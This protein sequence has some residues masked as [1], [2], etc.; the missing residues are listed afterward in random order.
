MT[1]ER[2][3]EDLLREMVHRTGENLTKEQTQQFVRYAELLRRWNEKMNLT[4]IVD[5]EGIAVKHILDSLMLLPLMD[6]LAE[7]CDSSPCLID[8]GS[9]AG[10]PGIPLVIMRPEWRGVLLDSMAKRIRFLDEVILSLELTTLKAKQDRAEDAGHDP[11]LREQF[12][13]VVAR[14]V[15]SLPALAE[16]CLPFAKVGGLFVAMKGRAD[17]EWPQA[18]RAVTLLGGQLEKLK[19]FQLPGTDQ[20]RSLFCIRKIKPTSQKYPRKAG[21]PEKQPL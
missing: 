18:E 2:S 21:K 12:D 10:L 6:A 19:T 14:A 9:G 5:D 17:S 3:F 11:C 13:L 4:A 20:T 7:K 1:K 8:V 15:A 16:Y